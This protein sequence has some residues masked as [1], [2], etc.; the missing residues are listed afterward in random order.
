VRSGARTPPLGKDAK[1]GQL[2]MNKRTVNKSRPRCSEAVNDSR[3]LHPE[4]LIEKRFGI[5]SNGN[6]LNESQ[7]SNRNVS[8]DEKCVSLGSLNMLQFEMVNS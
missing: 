4:I 5:K 1:F 7:P 6:D 8:R 3:F 2:L